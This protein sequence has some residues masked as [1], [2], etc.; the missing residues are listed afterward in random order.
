MIIKLMMQNTHSE[1]GWQYIDNINKVS[2]WTCTQ[3]Y[4]NKCPQ[5]TIINLGAIKHDTDFKYLHLTCIDRN[6]KVVEV[7]TDM[8]CYLL[9]DNGKTINKLN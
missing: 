9:N 8:N 2:Q 7:I 6:D 1:E 4:A 5:T 3:E